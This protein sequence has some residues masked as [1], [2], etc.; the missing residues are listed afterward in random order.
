MKVT[1]FT[2]IRNAIQLDFPIKEAITS[3]LPLC[4][5][6][7]VAVGD[8][9]D[10]TRALI[11]N[12]DAH[13]IRII[14]TVWDATKNER[15][16]VLADETNKALQQIDAETTWCI[17]IQGDEV[18]HE[19]DYATIKQAMEKYKND[20]SVDG[21]LFKYLHFYGSYDYV[22]AS[23]KWYRNEIRI[24]KNNK[25]VY[26]YRDAQGFRKGNNEKLVVK[27][28]DASIHHYGWVKEPKTMY[29]KQRNN[30][31]I[32]GGYDRKEVENRVLA[33]KEFD[34]SEIDALQLFKGTH[35][36]VMQHR[37]NSKN[38][39]FDFDLSKNKITLKDQFK[40]IAEKLFGVRPFEYKNYKLR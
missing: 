18:M 29:T 7:V 32:W 35:P 13:K 4:N 40:N 3:I 17:Y 39:Q 20:D 12:I 15:G 10:G 2:F 23:G 9:K 14:D 36:Q 34:Y 6:V 16:E 21:L 37:V 31:I 24:F 19:K 5:E 30:D 27:A 28:I 25:G 38:W 8:S 1:G 33:E 22:G 11:E 26:S